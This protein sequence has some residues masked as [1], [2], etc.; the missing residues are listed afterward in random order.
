MGLQRM[1]GGAAIMTSARGDRWVRVLL[2]ILLLSLAGRGWAKVK[3]WQGQITI[4]TYGWAEDVNPKFW[5]LEQGS[6]L[7]TTVKG[8]II[9]PYTMQDH[10]YREKVDRTYKA[11]FLENE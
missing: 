8:A 6:K 4:P 2:V 5:A 7:S 1:K 10:L 11:L 9:Y 3:A